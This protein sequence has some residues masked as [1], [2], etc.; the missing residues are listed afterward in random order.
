MIDVGSLSMTLQQLIL[1]WLAWGCSGPS[2]G[3][4]QRITRDTAFRGAASHT[5]CDEQTGEVGMSACAISACSAAQLM[6]QALH[7]TLRVNN[8]GMWLH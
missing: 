1:P 8:E 3:H 6:W 2:K 7:N 4:A 5:G